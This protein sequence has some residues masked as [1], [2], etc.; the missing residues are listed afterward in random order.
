MDKMS[1]PISLVVASIAL[2]ACNLGATNYPLVAVTIA[3]TQPADPA[4][5]VLVDIFSYCGDDRNGCLLQVGIIGG[6]VL[7]T[8]DSTPTTTFC[9]S[10]DDA[11]LRAIMFPASGRSEL[12]V[13]ARLLGGTNPNPCEGALLSETEAVV[14]AHVSRAIDAGIAD[15]K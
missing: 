15:A 10:H 6:Q 4:D 12:I 1:R 14:A 8:G 9:Q 7:R 13:Q 3:A 2:A 5:G 11:D